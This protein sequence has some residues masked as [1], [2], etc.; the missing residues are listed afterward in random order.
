MPE[1]IVQNKFSLA[2][3]GEEWKEAYLILGRITAKDAMEKLPQLAKVNEKDPE[4]VKGALVKMIELLQEK[5][6]SGKAV[7]KDGLVDVKKEDLADFPIEVISKATDFLSQ[8]LNQSLS[9]Q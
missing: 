2:F 4:A 7:T 9:K 3:L 5:F 1:F 8:G 6:F